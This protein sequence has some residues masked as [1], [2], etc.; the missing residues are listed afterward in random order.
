MP[1]YEYRCPECNTIYHE[2]LPVSAL[3]TEFTCPADNTDL[4]RRFGFNYKADEPA[5]YS[6][7]LGKYVSN[8]RELKDEFKYMGEAY[9]NRTGLDSNFQ[10]LDP[11]EVPGVTMEGL[12]ST[13]ERTRPKNT[14]E[15]ERAIGHSDK[16][17]AVRKRTTFTGGWE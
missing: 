14:A 2:H 15:I 9:S 8:T 11:R 13:F 7:A 4:I 12:D 10:P 6:T 17:K 5:G 1:L 3:D 16:P